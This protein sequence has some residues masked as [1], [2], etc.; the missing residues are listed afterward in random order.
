MPKESV[1]EL[2]Y[3]SAAKEAYFSTSD[4]QLYKATQRCKQ[5]LGESTRM[6]CEHTR[7]WRN[8]ESCSGI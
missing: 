3:L 1:Q 6:Y 7:F 5:E 2:W 4:S 8:D